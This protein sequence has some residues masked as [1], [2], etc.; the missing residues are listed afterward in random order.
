[1]AHARVNI[2]VRHVS[3][4]IHPFYFHSFLHSSLS[5]FLSPWINFSAQ[6]AQEWNDFQLTK[7]FLVLSQTS[8]RWRI[9]H[10]ENTRRATSAHR[11][12]QRRRQRWITTSSP[13]PSNT[14]CQPQT[15][16][17][18]MAGAC[19][20]QQRQSP[21]AILRL[22]NYPRLQRLHL[23][24]AD[25]IN[26]M[27]ERRVLRLSRSVYWTI[28]NIA[29]AIQIMPALITWLSVCLYKEKLGQSFLTQTT[30]R[31]SLD[32]FWLGMN[33]HDNVAKTIALISLV[34]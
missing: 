33:L 20:C 2:A 26:Y 28:F 30:R 9:R 3:R 19:I 21:I 22:D 1:M 4:P 5:L 34:F 12:P 13:S 25:S 10:L 18:A 24:C 7:F 11:R 6:V 8:A 29:I 27:T 23:A 31:N 17:P 14:M 16:K 32:H 15:S